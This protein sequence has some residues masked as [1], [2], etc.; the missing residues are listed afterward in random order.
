MKLISQQRQM[1]LNGST[2]R[3]S[4]CAVKWLFH[5]KAS[6]NAIRKLNHG[7]MQMRGAQKKW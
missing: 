1:K 4:L 7:E 3:F 5:R 2:L 6:R